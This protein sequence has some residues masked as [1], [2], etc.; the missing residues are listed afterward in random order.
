MSKITDATAKP[1]TTRP[2]KSTTP[3]EKTTLADAAVVK[4]ASKKITLPK[5]ASCSEADHLRL[6]IA[7]IRELASKVGKENVPRAKGVMGS[8]PVAV[9][10]YRYGQT[11]TVTELNALADNLEREL[12][13]K[14]G[15]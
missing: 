4:A 10:A 6:K 8:N 1:T 2:K 3:T 15:K 9:K 13:L 5:A 12:I 14:H 7:T 11:D